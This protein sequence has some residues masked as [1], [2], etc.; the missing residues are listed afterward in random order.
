ME[1]KNESAAWNMVSE[2]EL[3]YKSKVKAA[4]RPFVKCSS[5]IEKVLRNFYDENT[6]ELQ[7]QFY[8][9]YLN[10]AF[11]VLGIYKVSTGG[12]TGVIADPKLIMAM[13]LKLAS[14]Y[15]ILSHCHPSGNLQP[16]R[17]DVDLTQKIK[18]AAAFFDMK[19]LDHV[20]LTSNEYLSFTDEEA[21]SKV[22]G[23]VFFYFQF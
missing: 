10:R 19:V 14:C 7:E 15:L 8:V 23:A 12:I 11:R 9:M 6:I 13:A 2:V 20:I 22:K 17:A 5:D 1:R 21:V 16:S 3:T 18:Q 4:D